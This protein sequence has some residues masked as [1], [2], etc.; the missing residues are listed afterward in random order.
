MY[1]PFL[2][3]STALCLRLSVL[4]T[5]NGERFFTSE[6]APCEA[7]ELVQ[8]STVL[9]STVSIFYVLEHVTLSALL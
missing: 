6:H 2:T 8:R 7:K 4:A 5:V 9:S 1:V 3:P